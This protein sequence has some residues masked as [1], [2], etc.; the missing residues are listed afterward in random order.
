MCHI[1]ASIHIS[2]Q[3]SMRSIELFDFCVAC[4]Q[5]IAI[6]F[7]HTGGVCFFFFF[8]FG[9][10]ALHDVRILH[11]SHYVMPLC[12]YGWC[13]LLARTT[14]LQINTASPLALTFIIFSLMFVMI[15]NSLSLNHNILHVHLLTFTSHN[16]QLSTRPPAH[17]DTKSVVVSLG[18]PRFTCNWCVHCV[19]CFT[20]IAILCD[21]HY[22]VVVTTV[23]LHCIWSPFFSSFVPKRCE[24]IVAHPI[25]RAVLPNTC[26]CFTLGMSFV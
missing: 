19:T 10:N 5:H 11:W 21:S 17:A 24:I 8:Y 4:R 3:P 14:D 6:R 13:I 22:V 9:G 20:R 26:R 18:I 15:R 25:Q 2:H 1:L 12:C 7:W 16:A 23:E